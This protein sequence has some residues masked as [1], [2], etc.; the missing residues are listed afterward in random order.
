MVFTA[1]IRRPRRTGNRDRRVTSTSGNSGMDENLS[2][3]H[4]TV[5]SKEFSPSAGGPMAERVYEKLRE[6]SRMRRRR[7]EKKAPSA[8]LRGRFRDERRHVTSTATRASMAGLRAVLRPTG[9]EKRGSP[10]RRSRQDATRQSST[11]SWIDR[12]VELGPSGR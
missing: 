10:R 3:L 6:R 12:C 4:L 5:P 1:L 9:P 7:K 11:T 8:H 2:N